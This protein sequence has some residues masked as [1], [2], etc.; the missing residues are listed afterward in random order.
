MQTT[1][2]EATS[3]FDGAGVM[4]YLAGH[5]VPGVESGDESSYRRRVRLADGS[6]TEVVVRLAGQ[7]AVTVGTGDVPPPAEL[8]PRIRRLFDLDADSPAIDAHLAADPALAASVAAH[9]G[10]RLPGSLDAH[11]QLLRTMVGQQ[12]SI[13]AANTVLARLSRELGGGS[14]L[15]PTAGQFAERGLEV[16]RGPA[17]R[18]AAI[19]GAALALDSGSLVIDSALSIDELHRRLM[20]LPGVGVWTA[21]YVAMRALGAPDVLLASDL[22]LLK[23]AARLGLPATARGIAEFGKRWAPYRSYAGLH[24]WRAAQTPE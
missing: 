20:A 9:P 11:E 6:V 3:P 7:T 23:G 8:L 24:L 10:I 2:L 12:I 18:I 21:G 1:R 19:H 22:V 4:R 15:F 16:L 5:A 13:T 17:S 14:G